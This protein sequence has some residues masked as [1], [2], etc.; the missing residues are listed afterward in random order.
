MKKLLLF[1]IMFICGVA[2][3]AQFRPAKVSKSVKMRDVLETPA[4]DNQSP[5]LQAGNPVVNTKAAMDDNIGTSGVYDMQSNNSP[6]SRVVCWPDG[7]IA[8][9][10]IKSDVSGYAEIGRA[11]V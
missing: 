9:T 8:A 10:W 3:M 5:V 11:H 1:A 4:I 2:V 6:S 7:T